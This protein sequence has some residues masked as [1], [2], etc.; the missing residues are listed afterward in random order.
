MI[1]VDIVPHAFEVV[2]RLVASATV[3]GFITGYL[4]ELT[5]AT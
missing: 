1:T 4:L 3:A 2:S 5:S